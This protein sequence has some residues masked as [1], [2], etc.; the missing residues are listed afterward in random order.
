MRDKKSQLL[1][2]FFYTGITEISFHTSR[3]IGGSIKFNEKNV[4][5]I[6]SF[7]IHYKVTTETEFRETR[8]N[9]EGQNKMQNYISQVRKQNNCSFKLN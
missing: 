8:E 2:L 4:V 6:I 9:C 1:L 3:P 7:Q 5:Q